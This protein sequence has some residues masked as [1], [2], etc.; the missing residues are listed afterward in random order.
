MNLALYTTKTLATFGV[1]VYY[2]HAIARLDDHKVEPPSA[3][4]CLTFRAQAVRA[5]M[6]IF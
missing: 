3:S 4:G 1:G 6:A 5:T 2:S